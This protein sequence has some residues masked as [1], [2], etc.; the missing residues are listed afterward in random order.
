MNHF[1]LY[2]LLFF[3]PVVLA[4][5]QP[6][7]EPAP[8]ESAPPVS[9]AAS[10][11]LTLAD[12]FSPIAPEGGTGGLFVQIHGGASTDTLLG[13]QF[14]GARRVEL[15]ETYAT[16]DGLRGMRQINGLPIPA[17][18]TVALRPGSFHLMLMGLQAPLTAGD[19]ITV[20]LDFA[21]AGVVPLRVPVYA[22]E[23]L[24]TAHANH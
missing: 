21:Q 1:L 19:T 13:A 6:E 17:G 14:D 7:Q 8:A 18:E 23:D 11:E 15:H 9:A 3:V 4:G 5:C 2:L 22:P 16:D 12:P 10:S 20:T 24:P